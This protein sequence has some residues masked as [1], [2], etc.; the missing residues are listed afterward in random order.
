MQSSEG[1]N[2]PGGGGGRRYDKEYELSEHERKI[3]EDI[4]AQ[5]DER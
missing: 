4:E 5:F 3:Y 1:N 2:N